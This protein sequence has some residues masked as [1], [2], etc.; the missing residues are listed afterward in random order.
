MKL[1]RHTEHPHGINPSS[2][3]RSVRAE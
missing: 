2:P 1:Q 3:H